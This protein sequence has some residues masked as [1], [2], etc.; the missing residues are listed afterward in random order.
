LKSSGGSAVDTWGS[1]LGSILDS[2]PASVPNAVD[3]LSQPLFE[4]DLVTVL[5]FIQEITLKNRLE[6]ETFF[7]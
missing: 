3:A 1:Y 6:K 2:E 5:K 4:N 7:M